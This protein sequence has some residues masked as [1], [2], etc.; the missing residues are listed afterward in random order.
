MILIHFF[1]DGTKLKITCE[2]ILIL[3][4]A[5]T[6]SFLPLITRHYSWISKNTW[7]YENECS[8]LT[9]YLFGRGKGDF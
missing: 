9:F 3:N 8:V 6:L 4:K 7:T 2:I 5:N 1:E